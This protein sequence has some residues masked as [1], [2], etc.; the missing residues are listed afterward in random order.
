MCVRIEESCEIINLIVGGIANFTDVVATFNDIIRAMKEKESKLKAA[1]M[2][3]YVRRGGPNY[4][5]GLAR[6]RALGDEIGI[7]IE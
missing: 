6:M 3:I 2:H 7:S 1:N 4:Q 5:K